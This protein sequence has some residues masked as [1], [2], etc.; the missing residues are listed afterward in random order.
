[1][2][3]AL[4]KWLS[5][6][7]LTVSFL[8]VP[9][10]SVA[11]PYNI[12]NK[13]L[14][15]DGAPKFDY[16]TGLGNQICKF[17]ITDIQSVQEDIFTAYS[18]EAYSNGNSPS[19]WGCMAEPA[20]SISPDYYS[21]VYKTTN[22]ISWSP[23]GPQVYNPNSN[24][25]TN[26]I[27]L[28]HSSAS[29][30]RG[31]TKIARVDRDIE[32]STIGKVSF[33]VM[34]HLNLSSVSNGYDP[35]GSFHFQLDDPDETSPGLE[36]VF[37]TVNSTASNY[38]TKVY[39]LGLNGTSG[40]KDIPNLI[41]ES[42]RGIFNWMHVEVFFDCYNDVYNITIGQYNLDFQ[43][44][45]VPPVST[46]VRGKQYNATNWEKRNT[47][48]IDIYKGLWKDRYSPSHRVSSL[49]FWV[50]TK[51]RADQPD[52]PSRAY[53]DNVKLKTFKFPAI[54]ADVI[55]ENQTI[56]L[57]EKEGLS[58]MNDSI[59]SCYEPP[60]YPDNT[61]TID[62]DIKY[63]LNAKNEG[64]I[65]T[66]D[67][68]PEWYYYLPLVA[69]TNHKLN[70]DSILKIL[71]DVEHPLEETG[72]QK[73]PLNSLYKKTPG[74]SIASQYYEYNTTGSSPYIYRFD[75][76]YSD[77]IL[78]VEYYSDIA[79]ASILK[80]IV[81]YNFTTNVAPHVRFETECEGYG[82]ENDPSIAGF[83]VQIVMMVSGVFS[84]AMIVMIKK[85]RKKLE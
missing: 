80:E 25:S 62:Y 74:Y 44:W 7:I 17:T 57:V 81:I 35:Y 16:I 24:G 71:N 9:S 54:F 76:R 45:L 79:R 18:D 69:T 6:L 2:T 37:Q 11:M 23:M 83:P 67:L 52:W 75:A 61:A 60:V 36:L 43:D 3:K 78:F 84:L 51:E 26:C 58:Y 34:T 20:D 68:A 15:F 33:D 72:V 46:I 29:N 31:P 53:I 50:E 63:L 66:W 41:F 28:E 59:I 30:S 12:E 64:F 4:K 39:Y 65:T 5:L 8:I 82:Y 85:K 49:D 13:N 70:I 1:M 22:K 77:M 19:E 27:L 47:G 56:G 73:P 14:D 21:K 40:Y 48:D 10:F 55:L 42:F 38:T 32:P